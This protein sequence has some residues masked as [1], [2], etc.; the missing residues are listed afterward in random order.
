MGEARG[1]WEYVQD[2]RRK[3]HVHPLATLAGHVLTTAEPD[4]HPWQRGL[5][6]SIKF[7]DGDNFWEELPPYGVL[8]HVGDEVVE[9]IRPDRET[10]AL[11]EQRH[12]RHLDLGSGAYAI[13]WESELVSPADTVLDRTEYTT[14][15]GYGGLALR[16]RPDWTDTEIRLDDGRTRDRAVAVESRWL[17]LTG[18]VDGAVVGITIHDHPTNA[19]H[20]VPWYASTLAGPGYGDGWANFVNAAFLFHEPLGLAAGAPLSLR[21]RVVVHDGVAEDETI[22]RW[23]RDWTGTP[24]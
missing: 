7:V 24:G 8:R 22:E 9:W 15:G 21:Y 3:P 16:G 4:D 13:D 18:I 23:W 11:T 20:P 19:R 6:F 17:D 10:V 12:L 14:W 2:H 5:W 1:P